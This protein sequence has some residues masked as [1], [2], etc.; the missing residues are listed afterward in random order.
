VIHEKGRIVAIE[1]E[2]LWVE[3]IQRSTCNSC[4]A[5]KGC[6]QSMMAKLSGHTSYIWVLLQGR[7][8]DHFHLGDEVEIGVPESLVVKGSL[9][10]Y[11]VP[12]VGMVIAAGIAHQQFAHEGITTLSAF[13]GLLLG[14]LLVRW[15]S[16]RTRFDSNLQ[17]VLIDDRKTLQLPS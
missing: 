8:P 11:M 7:D 12:L 16:H 5:E 14:G 15:R 2:G 10:A 17:P 3:T 13:V 4:S 1:P 6:G 9:F